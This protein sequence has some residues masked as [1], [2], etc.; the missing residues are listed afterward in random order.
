MK[1][2]EERKKWIGDTEKEEEDEE[3]LDC[4]IDGRVN[5]GSLIE[6]VV[7]RGGEG[8]RWA[9]E[10][11]FSF[12]AARPADWGGGGASFSF[13][14]YAKSSLFHLRLIE[15]DQEEEEEEE[16]EQDHGLVDDGDA[17]ICDGNNTDFAI[18][19]V[20]RDEDDVKGEMGALREKLEDSRV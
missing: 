16:E 18:K 8:S 3:V 20:V 14:V 2:D 4:A 19:R 6:E 12:K 11:G 15:I 17:F 9:E 1:T 7:L 13:C 5:C 10:F